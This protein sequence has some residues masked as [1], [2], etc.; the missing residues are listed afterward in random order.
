MCLSVTSRQCYT[1][2]EQNSLHFWSKATMLSGIIYLLVK[3]VTGSLSLKR[4]GR[5]TEGSGNIC[6]IVGSKS[7]VFKK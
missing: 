1:D 3:C 7:L 5:A 4:K 2:I 6:R